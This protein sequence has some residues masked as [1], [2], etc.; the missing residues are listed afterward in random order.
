MNIRRYLSNGL[1]LAVMLSLSLVSMAQTSGQTSGERTAVFSRLEDRAVANGGYLSVIVRIDDQGAFQPGQ[2]TNKDKLR[3]AQDAFLEKLGGHVENITR[4]R[5]FPFLAY[6]VETAGLSIMKNDDQVVSVQENLPRH[7]S[8]QQSGPILGAPV[9][10]D[11]GYTGAGQY[12]AVIDSGVDGSHTFLKGSVAVEACFSGYLGETVCPNGQ[13]E[14]HGAG[15]AVPCDMGGCSHGTHV[16]GIVAGNMTKM[17]GIAKGAKIV[18]LQVGSGDNDADYCGDEP[19][20]CLTF[21]DADIL[22]AMD[23]VYDLKQNQGYEI[24]AVNMSLGGEDKFTTPCDNE[25]PQYRDA[26]DWLRNISVATVVA[27]GNESFKDG[28]TAPAC[29][30]KAISVGSICDSKDNDECRLGVGELADSSNVANYLSLLAPGAWITSSVP[31]SGYGTWTGTSMA[32]PH[33]AGAWAIM[34]QRNPNASVED[35]LTELRNHGDLLSDHR[36]GG[37]VQNMRIVNLDFLAG[38][39]GDTLDEQITVRLEEPVNGSVVT[40]VGNLRGWATG[41]DGIA[42]LEYYINGKLQGRIPYGGKR[43]D[44]HNKYPDNPGSLNS[45]YGASFNY[46]LLAEGT[47]TFKV[48]AYTSSGKYNEK[49]STVQT[50]KFHKPYF[51]G[52]DAMDISSSSVSRDDTGI[53]LKNVKLEGVPYDIRLEWNEATQQ[54]GI[55]EIQ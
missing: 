21:W 49:E 45:G 22:K 55:V 25:Y 2:P 9:A 36:N 19:V 29:F 5:A 15:A 54:F 26:I 34:K 24:A 4:F 10:W 23:Y 8:L 53:I 41:P 7:P 16:A 48:R 32:A 18:A 1:L 35:I 42:Y 37:V 52:D 3:A 38:S 20:P 50:I 44:I 30:S 39:G 28:L 47:H 27:S 31:G 17:H 14:Q 46:N 12:V 43:G 51:K 33:V 13:K 6:T 11:A 40:G